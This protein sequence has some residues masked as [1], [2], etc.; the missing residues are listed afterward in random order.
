MRSFAKNLPPVLRDRR[1][2][3]RARIVDDADILAW[4]VQK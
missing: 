4:M 1:Q 2:L 3:A